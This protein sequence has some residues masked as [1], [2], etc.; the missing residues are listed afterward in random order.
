MMPDTKP[1]LRDA[2]PLADHVTDYDLA[3]AQEYLRLLDADREGACWQEAA[4]IV[5][6]LDCEADAERAQR[7]HSAHLS[8]A[9]W[10]TREG[11]KDLLRRKRPQG[12]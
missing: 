10:M 2:P 11:W 7:I 6:E 9:L 5:L 8:R 1:A 4:G 3:Y 12:A